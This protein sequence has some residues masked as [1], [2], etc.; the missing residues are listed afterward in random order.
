MVDRTRDDVVLLGEFS[1]AAKVSHVTAWIWA[2]SGDIPATWRGGRFEI[3]R[4][5]L[6]VAL[7]IASRIRRPR[8]QKVA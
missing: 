7:E 2:R 1:R 8:P 5:D 4:A 6:P 3:A